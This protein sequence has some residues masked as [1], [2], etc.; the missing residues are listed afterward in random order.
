MKKAFLI[1]LLFELSWT[2]MSQP[3]VSRSPS[4]NKS[5]PATYCSPLFAAADGEYLDLAN[6]SVGASAIAYLNILDWLQGRVAGLQIVTGRDHTRIPLIRS[7]RATVYVDEL[8]VSYEFLNSLPV[9][10]IAMIK[11]IR[12]P[13][14]GNP[15]ASAG[16]IAIY[17]IRG[18]EE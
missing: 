12:G 2:A 18:E 11:I 14:V 7:Q 9:T 15:G 17:T 16:T 10:D 13:F 3:T 8:R 4:K 5:L 6:S 1:L